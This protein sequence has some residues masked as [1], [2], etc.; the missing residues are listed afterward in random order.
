[1]YEKIIER[2]K[3]YDLREDQHWFRPGTSTKY[4]YEKELV[5]MDIEKV[6][7]SVNKK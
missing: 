1:M 2:G 7:A 5:F 6:H 4:K 3:M